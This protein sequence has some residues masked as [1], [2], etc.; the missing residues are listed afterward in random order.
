[1][2]PFMVLSGMRFMNEVFPM[3]HAAGPMT[4]EGGKV[5]IQA[6]LTTC[7]VR[8]NAKIFFDSDKPCKNWQYS[9]TSTGVA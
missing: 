6:V 8:N 4:L 3:K 5:N 1:M 7:T 2:L 9:I